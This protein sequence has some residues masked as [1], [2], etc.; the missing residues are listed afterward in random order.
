MKDDKFSVKKFTILVIGSTGRVGEALIKKLAEQDHEVY[1]GARVPEKVEKTKSIHPIQFDLTDDISLNADK[2]SQMDAVYFVAGSRGKDLLQS[3]LFGSVNAMKAAEQAG[4]KRFIQ[5]SGIFATEPD[6]WKNRLSSSMTDYYIARY[7]SDR[8]LM[9]NT[10]L[11]YTILQPG[12]LTED[13]GTNL[14]EVNVSDFLDNSIEDVAATLV[15]ILEKGNTFKK[16]ITMHRGVLP[17]SEA[18]DSI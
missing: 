9:D 18:I 2:M 13:K 12:T 8:W 4:I 16:V 1:A 6:K 5:L 14:I 10:S 17:I 7:F 3:D 15:A 11:D